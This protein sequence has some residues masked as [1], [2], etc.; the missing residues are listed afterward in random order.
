[1]KK[2]YKQKDYTCKKYLMEF[3]VKLNPKIEPHKTKKFDH[4]E[5]YHAEYVQTRVPQHPAG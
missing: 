5:H 3:P 1:M 2:R 4:I